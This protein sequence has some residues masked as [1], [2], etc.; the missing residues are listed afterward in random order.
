MEQWLRTVGLARYD[1][2]HCRAERGRPMA[3]VFARLRARAGKRARGQHVQ[4]DRQAG[5]QRGHTTGVADEDAHPPEQ[6]RPAAAVGL[7]NEHV[8]A[9]GSRHHR[10]EFGIRENAGE[11]QQSRDHPDGEHQPRRLDIAGHHPRLEEDSGPDHFGDDDRDGGG[12]AKTADQC[13]G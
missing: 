12:Q 1:A 11:R 2:Y 10:G 3:V 13:G 8:L 7:A 9:A 5:G 4:K 6:E